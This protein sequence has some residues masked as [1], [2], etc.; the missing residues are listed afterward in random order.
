MKEIWIRYSLSYINCFKT[1]E[2]LWLN[3]NCSFTVFLILCMVFRVHSMIYKMTEPLRA[4]SLV[5]MCV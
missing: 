3:R 5:D 4:L 2:L 1:Q